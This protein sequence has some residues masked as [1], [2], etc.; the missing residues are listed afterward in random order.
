[1]NRTARRLS[2]LLLT[3]TS[4]LT[5]TAAMAAGFPER[6]VRFLVG[7]PPGGGTD[8]L[9]RVLGRKLADKWGQPVVVENRPGAGGTIADDFVAHA[10]TD[11]HTIGMA[12]LSHAVTP[13]QMKLNYDPVKSFAPVIL[14]VS[15]PEF[16]VVNSA[17]QVSTVK[18]LIALAKSKPGQ[19]NY[20]SP[21]AGSP[22][23]LLAGLLM[24]RTG[25]RMVNVTYKGS[26]PGIAALL[27]NEVQVTFAVAADIIEHAKS[28]RLKMLGVST[29][30]RSPLAPDVPTIAEAAD[31][32]GY[33]GS[34]W[35]GVLAPAGTPAAIVNRLNRDFAEMLKLPD[36]QAAFEKQGFILSGSSPQQFADFLKAETARWTAVL[37]TFP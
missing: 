10:P 23:L 15:A 37:K 11:G 31:L 6:P 14:L 24:Q 7:F 21:G 29:S 1:M 8:L 26:A 25:I 16:L 19:L 18:E 17:L 4:I 33:E 20:F 34:N 5:T 12:T 32:P 22:Q 35:Y 30:I 3:G 27:G 2:T 13:S 28:G 36:V 9:A